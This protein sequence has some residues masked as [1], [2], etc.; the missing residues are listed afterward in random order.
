MYFSCRTGSVYNE[1]DGTWKA[2]PNYI[3]VAT[4][5]I[6]NDNHYFINELRSLFNYEEAK[7]HPNLKVKHVIMHPG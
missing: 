5:D 2:M 4:V 1:T 3:I 7:K 6:P